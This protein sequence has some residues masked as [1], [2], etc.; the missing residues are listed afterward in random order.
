M[1]D[2]PEPAQV[3]ELASEKVSKQNGREMSAHE[4]SDNEIS[5]GQKKQSFTCDF[6]ARERD[7]PTGRVCLSYLEGLGLGT[8]SPSIV[9]PAK[10][11]G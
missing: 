4:S 5:S 1:R 11:P 8:M 10:S 7:G 9:S 6:L 2:D 3:A